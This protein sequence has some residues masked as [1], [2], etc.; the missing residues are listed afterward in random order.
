MT[1]NFDILLMKFRNIQT[2]GYNILA[3]LRECLWFE[4]RG[5]SLQRFLKQLQTTFTILRH[6]FVISKDNFIYADLPRNT[7]DRLVPV[8]NKIMFRNNEKVSVIL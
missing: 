1:N 8:Y 5:N 6:L 7:I 2:G 4:A 3:K